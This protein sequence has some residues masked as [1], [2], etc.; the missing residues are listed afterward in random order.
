MHSG[1]NA[2]NLQLIVFEL[3]VWK[4]QNFSITQILREIKVAKCRY[5]N[6]ATF[7]YLEALNFDFYAFLYFLKAEIYK[8]NKIQS[9]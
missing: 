7:D 2:W 4:L 3:T 8:I 5:P 6:S 1:R 9:P